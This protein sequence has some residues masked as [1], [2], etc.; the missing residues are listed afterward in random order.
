MITIINTGIAGSCSDAPA[1]YQGEC[2]YMLRVNRQVVA[3]FSHVRKQG[4]AECLRKAAEA[5]EKKR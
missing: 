3:E 1:S 4:L 5:V 2:N